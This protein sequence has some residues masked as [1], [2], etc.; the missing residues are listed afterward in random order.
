MATVNKLVASVTHTWHSSLPYLSLKFSKKSITKLFQ[1]ISKRINSGFSFL[2]EQLPVMDLLTANITCLAK[3]LIFPSMGGGLRRHLRDILIFCR[4]TGQTLKRAKSTAAPSRSRHVAC[5]S[6]LEGV[7]MSNSVSS[8]PS[9]RWWRRRDPRQ[10]P[11]ASMATKT[12]RRTAN[13]PPEI[14][15]GRGTPETRNEREGINQMTF[16]CIILVPNLCSQPFT[17]PKRQQ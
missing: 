7:E 14:S 8:S 12:T 2:L 10:Q 16:E 3:L 13:T 1:P 6:S 9:A 5:W 4:R 11:D 17:P 15:H